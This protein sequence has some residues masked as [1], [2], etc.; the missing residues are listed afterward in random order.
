MAPT[1]DV[2]VADRAS[3]SPRL[4]IRLP[5]PPTGIHAFPVTYDNV[6]TWDYRVSRVDLRNLYE[7]SKDSMWNARTDLAWDTYVDSEA[8]STPD[9]MNPIFGTHLWD[10]LD[11]KTEVPKLR[12]HFSSW[13]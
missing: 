3:S 13:M 5:E 4:D 8:P 10:K 1:L 6:F 2:A 7:K 12:R 9:P 11:P